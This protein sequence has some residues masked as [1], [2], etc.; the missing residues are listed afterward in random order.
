MSKARKPV[1]LAMA[2]AIA[3][4]VP[5]T[6]KWEGVW[7]VAKPDTLAYGIPTVCYGETEGVHVGDRYTLAQCKEM[8][9]KKLPRY[10]N[11]IA[12]CIKVDITE[13]A[14]A[15]FIV[16]SYNVGSGGFCKSSTVRRL[17]A[18]DVRGA[19]DGLRAWIKAGGKVRQG[20]INRRADERDL[21]LSGE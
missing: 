17:N 12:Q 20:L 11:E 2:G 21:C 15:A 3:L 7:L 19:C 14:L 5:L 6:A 18:G 9:A 13:E 1:A 16:F 8:L 4:A 10:A